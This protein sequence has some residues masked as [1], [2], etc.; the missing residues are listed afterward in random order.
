MLLSV[1]EFSKQISASRSN[2]LTTK[3]KPFYSDTLECLSKTEYEQAIQTEKDVLSAILMAFHSTLT[4]KY[5]PFYSE[6][7]SQTSEDSVL[8]QVGALSMQISA[9]RS[10]P[11][12]QKYKPFYSETDT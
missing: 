12:S 6:T 8:Q 4:Q 1:G 7:E 2:P 9:S 10:T 3:Y 5:K 11:L